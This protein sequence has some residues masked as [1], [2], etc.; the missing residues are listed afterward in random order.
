MTASDPDPFNEINANNSASSFKVKCS[1]AWKITGVPDWLSVSPTEDGAGLDEKTVTIKPDSDN[2]SLDIDRT[3]TL[4][5]DGSYAGVDHKKQ[6]KVTQQHFVFD[7]TG[8]INLTDNKSTAKTIKIKS[9]DSWIAKTDNSDVVTVSP[10]NGAASRDK[11]QD[12]TLSI[13]TNYTDEPRDAEVTVQAKNYSDFKKTVTIN[14]PAYQFEV[15]GS[16]QT[17]APAGVEN[18]AVSVTCSGTWDVKSDRDW[19]IVKKG[20]GEFTFTVTSNKS[21]GKNDTQERTGTITVSTTDD[22]KNHFAPVTITVKQEGEKAS[23]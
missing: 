23:K 2:L 6:I 10:A 14:Q 19:L 16:A 13:K 1:D 3:A 21:D 7:V 4:V 11:E 5:I 18:Q 22:S 8:T 12:C 20:S 17:I 9:S 15:D